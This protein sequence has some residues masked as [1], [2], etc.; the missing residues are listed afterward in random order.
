MA[1]TTAGM[2]SMSNMKPDSRKAGR[3]VATMAIWPA[4]NWLRA[5]V[6]II[7][8]MPSAASRKRLEHAQSSQNEPRRGTSNSHT[9]MPALSSMLPVPRVK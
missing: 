5:R 3:K 9:A 6:E 2:L 1:C 8:P 7:S 4:T